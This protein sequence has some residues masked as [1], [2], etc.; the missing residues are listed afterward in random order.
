MNF[1]LL[2]EEDISQIVKMGKDF[3]GESEFPEFSTYDPEIF[4]ETLKTFVEET[5]QVGI[6]SE[7]E[8]SIKGFILF[9]YS[10]TYTKEPLALLYLFYVCPEYRK[11]RLGRLLLSS[12]TKIAKQDGACA[13]YGGAMANIPSIT[14][15][16]G[17]MYNKLGFKSLGFWGRKVL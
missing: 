6:V 12:A 5:Q 3:F 7:E 8:G 9:G 11:T 17:N 14:K 13:F 4:E 15:T 2:E 16:I 1:R 10:R